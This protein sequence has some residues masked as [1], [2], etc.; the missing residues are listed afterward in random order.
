MAHLTPYAVMRERSSYITEL[1]DNNEEVVDIISN[2]SSLCD[3]IFG[4]ISLIDILG[5]GEF[6]HVL[7]GRLEDKKDLIA[8]KIPHDRLEITS[9]EV[10]EIKE[11]LGSFAS[12][13]S[14][15][16]ERLI[17]KLNG[18]N[19]NRIVKRGEKLK[20]PIFARRCLTKE[21]ISLKTFKIPKGSYLCRNTIYSEFLIGLLCSVLATTR[22]IN[23]MD[24]MDLSMCS[25]PE[26][27]TDL[28]N[29]T[30]LFQEKMINSLQHGS[31]KIDDSI[32]IQVFHA[33]ACYQENYAISHNDLHTGNV[34]YTTNTFSEETTHV[35]LVLDDITLY[36][37][38]PEYIIKIGDFG[39]SCKYSDPM[40]F[41]YKVVNSGYPNI[42]VN[43]SEFYDLGTFIMTTLFSDPFPL[44][45]KCISYI[46][47]HDTYLGS[48]SEYRTFFIDEYHQLNKYFISST[49]RPRLHMLNELPFS[50]MNAYKLLRSSVFDKFRNKP[51]GIIEE[52]ATI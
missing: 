19:P 4:S 13:N 34:F 15:F 30:Y 14:E 17:I 37:P 48:E 7:G 11:T 47:I 22:S 8:I 9:V 40:I 45:F 5:T 29:A 32:L 46:L 28:L 52:A 24:I 42:P 12:R 38:K 6:S 51:I 36:I 10:N 18:G 44:L 39:H 20:F 2:Q 35:S 1:L 23:F 25:G 16:N 41:N 27:N 26:E 3:E 50:G 31:I 43:Y 49:G 33:I 21:N